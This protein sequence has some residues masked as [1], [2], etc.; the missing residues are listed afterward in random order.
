MIVV[1]QCAAK[2][3]C[4]AGY[5]RRKDGKRVLFV[6]EPQSAPASKIVDYACPDDVADGDLTWRDHL[7]G[8][9]AKPDGNPLKLMP[10][11]QL[12]SNRTYKNLVD[13]FGQDK[14]YILSAGWG[15]LAADF[16][17]PMYDITFSTSAEG[18]KRRH[19]RDRYSDFSML[20]AETAEPVAF[21]GGKD[22]VSLFC[23][24]TKDIKS[25]RYILYNSV[26]PPNAPGCELVRFNTT[27]RTN[28]HY[29]CAQAFIEGRFSVG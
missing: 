10:A 7:T 5:L 1:I 20:P 24:L 18:Y 3:S 16:L 25:A 14:L 11:W 2:K 23:E 22:Y 15:L 13:L 17:T 19:S 4:S 29:L 26:S 28:W 9:N 8:Y 27:A 6:A 12:Y 21:F